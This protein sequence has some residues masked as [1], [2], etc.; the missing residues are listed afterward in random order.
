[1][2]DEFFWVIGGGEMQVP[3]I[4]EVRG[5][6]LKVICSDLNSNCVCRNLCDIFLPLD[7]FDVEGH[8]VTSKQLASR[9][10]IVGVLAAG[11]DAPETM[12]EVA[13]V[14][15]L[16]SVS[17]EIARLVHNK[18][19]FRNRLAELGYPV[20][21]FLEF[22][23]EQLDRIH[24][25][26]ESIG[27]PLI[28]KNTDSSASRGTRILR[29]KNDDLLLE[30]A[31]EAIR[32]SKSRKGLIESLWDGPEQTVETLYDI[33]GKF[34]RCFIT[35]REFDKSEGFALETGLRHPST[36][37]LEKQEALYSLAYDVSRAIGISVGA[38]KFDCIYTA[39]GPRII[40]M[41]V[42]L[43]GGFDC[44]YLV[45]AATGK[46]ILR[47]AILTAIGREF[48][49]QLLK[50]TRD[51]V[52]VSRSIWPKPGS[53]TA[54]NGLDSALNIEGVQKIIMR[55]QIGDVIDRY[56][57]CTKR[58]CFIIAS[59]ENEA[60]VNRVMEAVERTLI[61]RTDGAE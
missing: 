5:L 27:Y 53:I 58:V 34:H 38:A 22:G 29:V 13:R 11:I 14:L 7:I 50:P 41:T 23:E 48:P 16:P 19:M 2:V 55:K 43:S 36:L 35:D 10:K 56:S 3:L 42:R 52:A 47:A 46:N 49:E 8:V 59:G 61:I 12:T 25:L 18:S 40:E 28:V 57:D 32:V 45:P 24:A 4:N 44:Q 15:N 51:F 9:H 17:S 39:E 60:E 20:P 26:A 31:K 21:K 6:G 30:S 1:M 33:N 54:I 37:S